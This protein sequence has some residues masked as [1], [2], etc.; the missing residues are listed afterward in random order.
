MPKNY[1]DRKL[2]ARYPTDLSAWQALKKHHRDFMRDKSL[3]ELFARDKERPAKFSIEA[4]G[5]LLDYSKNHVNNTTH[6]LLNRLAKQADVPAAIEAMFGGDKIN[7]TEG[8]SVLHVALR[9][10]ISDTV[11]LSAP[12]VRD[13]WQVLTKM[14]EFVDAVHASMIKGYTGKRLTNIVNIGIGGSDLG[15]VMASKALRPYWSAGMRFHSVSNIDGT[16]L[17]DLKAE[18]DPAR[19][20]FVVCSKTFTTIET[21]SNANAARQ[22]VVQVL[23]EGAVAS[24]FVAASTNHAAMDEFG[25]APDRRFG[26]WD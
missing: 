17:A 22:W 8:R 21:M 13:I 15:P 19:T 25:I 12:G 24:H 2:S 6:K 18:L 3:R 4:G 11:A 20:L 14:E 1:T 26:F 5:L 7:A 9:S 10:K 16:Q 23:G